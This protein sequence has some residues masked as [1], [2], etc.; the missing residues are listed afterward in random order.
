EQP[1]HIIGTKIERCR[2]HRV[3]GWNG[4]KA[5]LP[6]V[7]ARKVVSRNQ[8][9]SRICLDTRI[10]RAGDDRERTIADDGKVWRN[11][12]VDN[13]MELELRGICKRYLLLQD[14]LRNCQNVGCHC[15]VNMHFLE[16]G[17]A[18]LDLDVGRCEQAGG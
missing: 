13:D 11:L 18:G 12:P 8:S 9:V 3:I 7:A 10:E 1:S 14:R 4:S 17:I 15:P 6:T 16:P 5:E 2:G